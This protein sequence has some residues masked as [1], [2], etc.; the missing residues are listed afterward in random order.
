[1][2]RI[3]LALYTLTCVFFITACQ[4]VEQM[5]D[6]DGSALYQGYCASCHGAGGAGDGPVAGSMTVVLQDLRG[7]KQ[8]NGGV[9]P[10]Q[11]VAEAIDGRSM[12][13][14][15]G[16]ADMPVWG[17]EF[18]QVEESDAHTQARIDALVSYLEGIQR[19]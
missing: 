1:M 2:Q 5:P 8:R 17:W 15:H 12:R 6:Y 3:T 11:Q 9:F 7:I 13:A 19:N 16:T 18:G 10:R 4:T 14:A